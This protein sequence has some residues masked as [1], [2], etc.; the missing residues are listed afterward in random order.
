MTRHAS[1]SAI[2]AALL[3]AAMVL[4]FAWLY[5]RLPAVRRHGYLIAC[6]AVKSDAAGAPGGSAM[7]P[8]VSR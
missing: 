1:Y 4:P 7:V 8:G 5:A 3:S 6:V 2:A